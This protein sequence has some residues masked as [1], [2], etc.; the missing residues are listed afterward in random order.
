MRT[1]SAQ[2]QKILESQGARAHLR[3]DTYIEDISALL[4]ESGDDLLLETGDRI[5]LDATGSGW[6]DWT[7]LLGRDWV[8][9][10][11][12]GETLDEPGL[13][14]SIELHYRHYV[15]S[16]SP[17]TLG[18]RLSGYLNLYQRIRI[19]TAIMPD[20]QM[21][22]GSGDWQLMF[23]GRIDTINLGEATA[24]LSCRDAITALI[25]DRQREADGLI[26]TQA[27]ESFI[28]AILDN[29]LSTDAPTLYT[30]TSPS[31]TILSYNVEP[32]SVAEAIRDVY[33]YIGWDCRP[34]WRSSTSQ[35]ELTLYDPDRTK[36]SADY[37]F[38]ADRYLTIDQCGIDIANIRN[39]VVVWY[40]DGTTTNG[41]KAVPKSITR[42]DTA[43]IAAYGR[44]WMEITEAQTSALDTPTEV[45][46]FADAI[47]SD[48]AQP[49]MTFSVQ[50]PYFWPIELNDL[51]DFEAD[52]LRFSATQRLAVESYRHTIS[53]DGDASTSIQVSGKPKSGRQVW[54][55][56]ESRQGQLPSHNSLTPE[57]P[58]INVT[59]G[60]IG[61]LID[62]DWSQRPLL[63]MYQIHRSTSSGFTPGESTLIGFARA[64]KGFWDPASSTL[65]TRYYKAI[66]LDVTGNASA[67]SAQDSGAATGVTTSLL[68]ASLRHGAGVS[69]SGDQTLASSPDLV[70]WDTVSWGVSDML[71]L[72]NNSIVVDY[73]GVYAVGIGIYPESTAEI[74]T[75]KVELIKNGSTTILNSGTRSLGEEPI[76]LSADISLSATDELTVQV[77]YTGTSCIIES[78]DS[79]FSVRY[80]LAQQ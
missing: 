40:W 11:D 34:K 80:T 66:A 18:T 78:T 57:T 39:V 15:D 50:A 52:G 61:M 62:V 24:V 1:I 4:L 75:W 38:D 21:A 69:L 42:T 6:I 3:I 77:T 41:T 54:L 76:L 47:L 30:P 9:S 49:D 60:P 36:A 71:D 8:V 16:A 51:Y 29:S 55:G 10:A 67:A 65:E 44:R 32:M 28:Q 73:D 46:A 33:L 63:D 14:A 23:D 43:S 17:Y 19:Y 72:G 70:E 26:A 5:L 68:H 79:Y 12:W 20:E 22:P 2:Q 31:F 58:T 13:N 27:M 7:Q 56:R 35:F 74:A 25:I 53:A 59:S 45:Q 64:N 48:L 37:T